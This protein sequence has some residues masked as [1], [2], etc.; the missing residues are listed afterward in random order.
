MG[1]LRE[2][3]N[4]EVEVEGGGGRGPYRHQRGVGGYCTLLGVEIING[5]DLDA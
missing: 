4:I 3:E 2:D 1:R 5:L